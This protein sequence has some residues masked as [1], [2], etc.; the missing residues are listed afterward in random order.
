[1]T[2]LTIVFGL[3]GTGKTYV[4]TILRDNFGIHV[5]EAD[6]ELPLRM[7][8]AII[9]AH[10]VT[11]DMR[12]EF[13][14]NITNKLHE[15]TAAYPRVTL[16]QTFIKEIYR[17]QVLTHFPHALFMLVQTDT[18][19]R[20]KRLLQRTTFPLDISYARRMIA[21]FDTPHIPHVVVTN[22]EEGTERIIRQLLAIPE[23]TE[24]LGK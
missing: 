2:P 13:F 20:E 7:R 8:E 5:H 23:L 16:T 3:P 24:S 22:N 9:H 12:D 6:N 10:P 11:D 21:N 1:M 17:K 19:I 14:G 18:S 4:G 15:L